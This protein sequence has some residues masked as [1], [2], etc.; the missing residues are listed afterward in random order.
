MAD[1]QSLQGPIHWQWWPLLLIALMGLLSYFPMVQAYVWAIDDY[2]LS[3]MAR[4]GGVEYLG[5]AFQ[6]RGIWR[7]L[8]HGLVGWILNWGPWLPGLLAIGVHI[9]TCQFFYLV[10]RHL[11]GNGDGVLVLAIIAACSPFGFQAVSWTSALP[12]VL[13]SLIFWVSLWMF[14][15]I[16]SIPNWAWLIW[17]PIFAASLLIHEHLLFALAFVAGAAWLMNPQPNSWRT[18]LK[19]SIRWV[20]PLVACL[21]LGGYVLFKPQ[22]HLLYM[23]PHFHWPALLSPLGKLWQWLDIWAPVFSPALWQIAASEWPLGWLGSGLCILGGTAALWMTPA[24]PNEIDAISKRHGKR[25]MM[26]ML[27]FFLLASLIYVPAGGFSLDS[28][29]RYPLCLFLLGGGGMAIL[30]WGR[31][32]ILRWPHW[33]KRAATSLLATA[34]MLVCWLHTG[35]WRAEARAMRLLSDFLAANPSCHRVYASKLVDPA[36]I[37]PATLRLHGQ[38]WILTLYV[39]QPF[40]MDHPGQAQP[41]I[42][43]VP[44][45]GIPSISY[46]YRSREWTVLPSSVVP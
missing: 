13:S 29:K 25:V 34:L 20:P 18:C 44:S 35:L 26:V 32:V 1:I 16:H 30:T 2:P 15:R 4:V 22:D 41:V 45:P 42:K 23:E 7:L 37:S 40:A 38:P 3:Q 14:L 6:E 46:D 24:A 19:P 11:C 27:I 21:Y 8:Q 9:V 12:Y 39:S 31:G 36:K 10:F 33:Q 28:R 43:D 5:N 17:G